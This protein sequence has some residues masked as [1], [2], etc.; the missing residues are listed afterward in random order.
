[1]A[2]KMTLGETWENCLSMWQW[3]AKQIEDESKKGV[4]LLK[5]QWAE[6]HGFV[7]GEIEAD[8]FFCEYA[9][10]N[11]GGWP[12]CSKCPGKKIEPH[13]DCDYGDCQ[14]KETPVAFYNKLV[15][16]NKKR[17]RK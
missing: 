9:S 7:S 11:N 10:Q 12:G 1:M 14:W 8:C 3:V 6:A 13:F 2:K 17:N 15:G 4:I 5:R 16:L